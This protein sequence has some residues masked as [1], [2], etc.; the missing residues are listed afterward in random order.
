MMTVVVVDGGEIN[1]LSRVWLAVIASLCY[2]HFI[3]AT[4]PKG[5]CRLFSLSPIF[6]IFSI[7]PLHT[8]SA[9]FTAV[10][11]F[12]ITW[13]ANFKLLL[14]AFDRGPISSA[15]A[16]KSLPAFI[17]TAALPLKIKPP[18]TDAAGRSTAAP[19]KSKKVLPLN[20][21]TEIPISVVLISILYEC[22][23][24][25]H[26]KIVLVAYCCLVFLSVEILVEVSSL[27]VGAFLGF[28]LEP[29]SDEPYLSSSLREFWGR[30]W[31]LTVSS[32][33]HQT[34]YRP[35]WSA[36]AA[37]LGGDWAALPAVLAAFVV[38]GLM[39][40]LF[41]WYI[42][43]VSPTWEMTMFFVV[44]GVCVVVEFGVKVALA[45]RKW[46]LPWFVSGPLTVGFVVA[47]SF[48]LFFPPVMRNGAD[49]RV[50]EEFR[51]VG[52]L[53][54]EKLMEYSMR[55]GRKWA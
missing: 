31:N 54:K 38:S 10:T 33:L 2:C 3:S 23:D 1:N 19:K 4:L 24:Y 45:G 28:E 49:V 41:F 5:K 14:F 40:E 48:W 6:Y 36:A 26:P 30:R 15:G 7:L 42:T 51:F 46:R 27:L 20:L 47:T 43:R 52:E 44:Q 55:I 12:F 29:A 13:L 18:Q 39:H 8:N 21:A 50:I 11:V 32:I 9:F 34:V 37:V 35:V 22:R 53:V 25:I 16:P 17:A